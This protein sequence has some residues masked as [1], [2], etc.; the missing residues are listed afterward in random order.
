MEESVKSCSLDYI[1]QKLKELDIQ[2]NELNKLN[3]Q[4]AR[5]EIEKEEA[6]RKFEEIK[7]KFEE[8]MTDLKESCDWKGKVRF[9]E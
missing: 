3:L 7:A 2:T 4:V 9:G 5:S 8:I 1:K 6:S